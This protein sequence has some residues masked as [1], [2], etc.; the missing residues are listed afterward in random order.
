MHVSVLPKALAERRAQVVPIPIDPART[1]HLVID[2]Q[3][4]FM[5]PNAVSQVPFARELVP[6]VNSISRALRAAGGTNAFLRFTVDLQADPWPAMWDRLPAQMRDA[7]AADF[8]A[9]SEMHGLWPELDV[10][11]GDVVLDKTRFSAFVP[12]TCGLHDVLR[13]KAIETVIVTGTLTNCCC[14]STARDAM[15]LG[16]R[17]VFV[18]DANATLDDAS[19][20]A[21]LANMAGIF[22]DVCTAEEVLARL[23]QRVTA[24]A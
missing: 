24:A 7:M 16:Y 10:Q 21:T 19:H 14:E 11:P 22:G 2:L 12:G 17:M 18:Q 15:Q 13:S 4:G 8:T 5:A 3:S 9:G 20:N 23:G 1:A 6:Q